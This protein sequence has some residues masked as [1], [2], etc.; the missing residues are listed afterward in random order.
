MKRKREG[1][2]DYSAHEA[3]AVFIDERGERSRRFARDP[4]D[5]LRD[6][7]VMTAG[8]DPGV[9]GDQA[10]AQPTVQTGEVER[11]AISRDRQVE[12]A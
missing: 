10:A 9:L 3:R 8:D 1:D 6:G 2:G 4:A 7:D 5:I 12:I 11:G